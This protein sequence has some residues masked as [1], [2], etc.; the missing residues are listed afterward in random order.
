MGFQAI[1]SSLPKFYKKFF[2][3]FFH[4]EIPEE[5]FATCSNCAMICQDKNEFENVDQLRRK[6]FLASTKCC[7]YYPRL[8]N[9]LVGGLLSDNDPA[10][11]EGQIRIRQAIKR[12]IGITPYGV[13]PPG[14][15]SLLYREGIDTFGHSRYLRCPYYHIENGNCT[16]WKYR[17]AVCSTYFCKTVAGM[18]GKMFW[19]ALRIYLSSIEE[20]LC[21][22]VLL[23]M[24]FD[25]KDILSKFV[26]APFSK[27]GN[28]SKAGRLSI[29]EMDD[30]PPG[31]NAYKDMWKNWVNKEEA[32]YKTTYEIVNAL[33]RKDLENITGVHQEVLFKD[34]QSA[35]NKMVKIP[36]VVKLHPGQKSKLKN[37]G[38]FNVHFEGDDVAFGLPKV[39]FQ[40]FDFTEDEAKPYKEIQTL[41]A[42]NENI[43]LDDTLILSLYQNGVLING[44][45]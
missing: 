4:Q 38:M 12:K 6:P 31:E 5:S 27:N 42:E 23:Q 10:L 2:P 14:K 35:F 39:I 29:E 8:P 16:I 15:Y 40:Y 36:K 21:E 34:L 41:L 33:T 32:F 9:Y 20:S 30:L 22:Y 19:N 24:N 45:A 11:K 25:S 18:N 44:E 1:E 13:R 43:E 26:S 7:T 37:E 17:E 3:V 28:N